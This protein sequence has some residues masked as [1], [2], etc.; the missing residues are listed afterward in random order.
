M[1]ASFK[2]T[3]LNTITKDMTEINKRINTAAFQALP[4]VYNTLEKRLHMNV[5][6]DVYEAV[7]EPKIYQRRKDHPEFGTPLS[8][9]RAAIKNIEFYKTVPT[10][11]FDYLP[12]GQHSGKLANGEPMWQNPLDGDALIERIE[13]G[14]GYEWPK[15]QMPPRE[16]FTNFKNDII[17]GGVAESALVKGMNFVDPDLQVKVGGGKTTRDE[18]D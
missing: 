9:V 5:M 18:N 4:S 15:R 10:L 3:G 2:V 1:K 14:N 17:E 8:D 7:D 16:Y 6:V 13:S 11:K 12:S